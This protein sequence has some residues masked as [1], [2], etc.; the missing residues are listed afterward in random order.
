LDGIPERKSNVKD[1]DMLANLNRDLDTV[2]FGEDAVERLEKS[3]DHLPSEEKLAILKRD[4]PEFVAL[5]KDFRNSVEELRTT[6]IPL[7]KKLSQSQIK[8]AKGVSYLELKYH[9]LL[10]YCTNIC[11][12]LLLKA[13]GER[14]EDH[15]VINKLVRIRVVLEKVRPLDQKLKYQIDKLLKAANTETLPEEQKDNEEEDDAIDYKPNPSNLVAD[16]EPES[17]GSKSQDIYQA[18][19]FAAVPYEGDAERKKLERRKQKVGKSSIMNFIREEYGDE[20]LAINDFSGSGIRNS[21]PKHREEEKE[22]EK[23]EEERF[24]RLPVSKKD[25]KRKN[26][27]PTSGEDDF[28][29]DFN[30]I[31]DFERQERRSKSVNQYAD[32]AQ[33][34]S[35]GKPSRSADMD[36]PYAKP[37][38]GGGKGGGGNLKRKRDKGGGKKQGNK[39]KRKRK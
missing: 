35:S 38:G 16:E 20:P 21:T 12:Y 34:F 10:S 11:F 26:R 23:Y 32:D 33:S 14:V 18:P 28:L 29:E 36:L 9:L 15:P 2:Q 24:I 5:T 22:R 7:I 27:L 13:S 25:T 31:A 19:R 17:G 37:K 3:I 8:T 6:I 30:D 39:T 1:S 4:S